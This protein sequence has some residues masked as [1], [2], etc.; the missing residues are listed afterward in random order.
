MLHR[1]V[2]IFSQQPQT[3][4]LQHFRRDRVNHLNL[5]A[6]NHG[7]QTLMEFLESSSLINLQ[8]RI[9]LTKTQ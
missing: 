7:S 9:P 2:T 6:T 4:H 1:P 5:R 3:Q 8:F